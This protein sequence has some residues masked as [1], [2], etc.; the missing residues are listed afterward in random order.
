MLCKGHNKTY[1]FKKIKMILT[2][3]EAIKNGTITT[4]MAKDKQKQLA[5]S[6]RE[7]TSKTKPS[8]YN[9]K[10]RNNII[11]SAAALL[12]GREILLKAFERGM[13]PLPAGNYS[14]QSEECKQS[15][16]LKWSSVYHQYVSPESKN[17]SNIPNSPS[18]FN[19]LN[20]SNNLLFTADRTEIETKI[21]TPKQ[22]L[23]RLPIAIV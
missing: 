22:M 10:K 16:Q 6:I 20:D 7:L 5:K 12:K 4:Y 13:F 19:S 17:S 2:F 14:A 23:Q 18:Q 1:D 3:G 9:I 15:E 11:I 21:L 8:N